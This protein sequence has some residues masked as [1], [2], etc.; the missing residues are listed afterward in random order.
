MA[1]TVKTYLTMRQ[2][3]NNQ[4]VFHVEFDKISIRD[5]LVELASRFDKGFK[6][7]VFEENSWKIGPH[8]RILVNGKHYGTLPDKL[9]TILTSGDEIGLFPPIAGG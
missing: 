2:V 6:T 7:M 8:V 3:M 1:I 4:S 5:L 9:D